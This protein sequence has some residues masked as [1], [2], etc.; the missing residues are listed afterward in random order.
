MSRRG[1]GHTE[2]EQASGGQGHANRQRQ[3]APHGTPANVL[4]E[5]QNASRQ[6]HAADIPGVAP[7]PKCLPAAK[8]RNGS[9]NNSRR[10]VNRGHLPT[11][12]FGQ[13][14]LATSPT[15]LLNAPLATKDT[16]APTSAPT[17]A[18]TSAPTGP[19][20]ANPISPPAQAPPSAAPQLMAVSPA[21]STA[22][23]PAL[24]VC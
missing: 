9:K 17:P 4:A 3:G 12:P 20:T 14:Q 1:P 2:G 6:H 16:P 11:P 5:R 22:A 23:S 8:A 21:A 7:Q 15:T 24:P 13:N 19:P 18:P 10:D